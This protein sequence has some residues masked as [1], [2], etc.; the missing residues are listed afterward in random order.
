MNARF[1]KS[2]HGANRYSIQAFNDDTGDRLADVNVTQ[3]QFENG[4]AWERMGDGV[5]V[6][7]VYCPV[8]I[9][10]CAKD[11]QL[12]TGPVRDRERTSAEFPWYLLDI[13]EQLGIAAGDP[14]DVSP[15]SAAQV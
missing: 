13:R 2:V 4:L 7:I 3:S 6:C 11:G 5:D 10:F 1:Q 15:W 14:V 12:Y 9:L 8:K